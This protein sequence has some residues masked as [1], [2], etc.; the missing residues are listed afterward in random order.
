[1]KTIC[2]LPLL[3]TLM[4]YTL[5][6]TPLVA[7]HRGFSF[8]APENTVASAKLGFEHGADALELDTYLTTDKKL[9]V[10]HDGDTSRTTG[11]AMKVSESSSDELRKLDAGSWKDP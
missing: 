10:I 5:H 2:A 7:A 11:V 6:A 4:P 9:I 1:M 3:L 8:I